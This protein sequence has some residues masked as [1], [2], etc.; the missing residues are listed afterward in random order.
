MNDRKYENVI[1][2]ITSAYHYLAR[3]VGKYDCN[4]GFIAEIL[5]MYLNMFIGIELNENTFAYDS[6][7]IF[8]SNIDNIIRFFKF[9]IKDYDDDE[10]HEVSEDIIAVLNESNEYIFYYLKK[11]GI[12][13]YDSSNVIK[14]IANFET[15][16]S[17]SA[18]IVVENRLV[19]R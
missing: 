11:S 10:E 1:I 2:D 17:K 13:N 7:I 18:L 15:I 19:N 3:I 8:C 9:C 16:S 12:F 6:G 4:E 5:N 14:H